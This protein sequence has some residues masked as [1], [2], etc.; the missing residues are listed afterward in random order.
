[1]IYIAGS[2]PAGF[3]LVADNCYSAPGSFPDG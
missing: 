1:M 3:E 2:F